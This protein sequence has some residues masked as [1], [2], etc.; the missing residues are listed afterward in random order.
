M[1]KEVADRDV[2]A[3]YVRE[4]RQQL[5]GGAHDEAAYRAAT[6]LGLPVATPH[7]AAR[8]FASKLPDDNLGPE[9]EPQSEEPFVSRD[10]LVSLLQTS[11][12]ERL[13]DEG[14]AQDTPPEHSHHGLF[15]RIWHAVE[16]F[17]EDAQLTARGAELAAEVVEGTLARLADGT[18]DFNREPAEHSIDGPARLILV[19]DWGSGNHHAHNVA[20]LMAQEVA[21]ALQM[22][23]AVHVIHLG[24]VYFA[25]EAEEYRRNVLA[26]GWWPVTNDQA[27]KGA[28]SWS[29][30][31]NHD[32]YGGA[33]GY[34][35]VLLAE[36]RF[37]L[38][39]S[40]DDS[41]TSWFRLRLPSWDVI[42]LDSSWNDDPFERGQ[43]GLLED[44]QATRVAQWID[45][46]PLDASGAP[47]KRLLLT[48]HQF[49]T[50]YDHR[51]SDVLR[52]DE[53]PPMH[54]KLSD[55]LDSGAITAWI[56][57]HEHRCMAFEHAKVP[58]PRCLGHGGQL[59][60]A[61]APGTQPAP[62]GTWE[63]TASFR[64]AG[65]TWG[66]FGFAVLDIEGADIDVRYALDGQQPTVA[67]EKFT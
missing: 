29:L 6:R 48:H 61:H 67:T 57:G 31:G 21:D 50:V 43:T 42:G 18:H 55:V 27:D 51:L 28:G 46:D 53:P 4:V 26:D 12:A 45:E 54:T 59:L 8:L 19:G 9:T 11:L 39:R 24:D 14:L 64:D 3:T 34:F 41:P 10:P 16:D 63:E 35:T 38:Q 47:R 60:Q 65:H 66:A 22:A 49:L 5:E 20:K 30:A 7:D 32:L 25:G 2:V 17:V 13:E 52:R 62:P 44:P 56:W 36:A 58:F 33:E 1:I 37:R 40:A 15:S 23:R